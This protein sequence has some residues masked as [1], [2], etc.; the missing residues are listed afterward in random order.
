[1]SK[2]KTVDEM[3]KDHEYLMDKM[4]RDHEAFMLAKAD[5]VTKQHL[6][7]VSKEAVEMSTRAMGDLIRK[8]APCGAILA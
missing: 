6:F 8:A 3:V 1:M 2:P 7:F 5:V 4:I